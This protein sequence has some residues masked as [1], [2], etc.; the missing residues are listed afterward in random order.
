MIP[1]SHDP[2]KLKELGNEQ[3]KLSNFQKAIEFYT[4]AIENAN[5]NQRLVCLSNRAFAHIKMENYGLAIIDADE[6]LKDDSGFIKA[7]YR[8]GSA[9]LLLGKFDDAR[10][11][12]KRADSLTQGKDADIQAKL[13]QIKQ[14]IYE[15]EFAKSIERP[16]ESSEPIEIQD[17]IVEQGYDGPRIDNDI[18]EV[19]P[20]WCEKLMNHYKDQ[21]KLH[22]K[23]AVMILQ[24]VGEILKSQ[25]NVVEY[26]VPKDL[27]FTVCGDTHGQF[28][29]LLNI[30]KING[31][32]S[33]QRPY[34]FNGDFVD[35]GS[36]SVEVIMTLF[37]WKVCNP[38]IMHLTRGNHESRNMNKMYGFEGEVKHKY[39]DKVYEL[40]QTVFNYLPLAYT[41]SKQVMVVHGGLFSNDGVTIS[42][43]QK[44]NR[45]RDIPEGG[46]MADMLWSDPIKQNGRHPSKRG[47]S[48]SFGPDIAH[49]FLNENGLSLLVRS[50][51]MKDQ[52]YEV[53]A[54]GRVITIFSAPNYCDQMKNKGA[55]I[56]FRG[57]EMKPKFVQFDAVEHPKLPPMA[58]ARNYG[59]FM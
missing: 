25:Q 48:I 3:F 1:N 44:L 29:D 10:R 53:E 52:G 6:I 50:H 56:I 27:E 4:S 59:M 51:E 7:Y 17:I 40:F 24:K 55:F 22:K 32:P 49:K 38:D 39:D 21:K 42:E 23:Y 13:K 57:G 33:V 31:N 30:F 26:D 12:F 41:L 8:K 46:P 43:L 47:I 37:A 19:T 36:W 14:A 45:F 34:L 54:D 18:S 2:E 28:F 20:E 35:R 15:R 9:Y 58:Y 11:E 5:G 16:D